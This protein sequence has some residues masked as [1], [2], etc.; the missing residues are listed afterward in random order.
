MVGGFEWLRLG[1]SRFT[2]GDEPL[3][4]LYRKLC[5]GPQGRSWMGMEN[6]KILAPT[7]VKPRTLQPVASRH[8]LPF[9]VWNTRTISEYII[10]SNV[11]GTDH[12]LI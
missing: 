2:S 5:G 12:G 1:S 11:G 7:G 10:V 8:K 3:Y 4:A 6:R 9:M